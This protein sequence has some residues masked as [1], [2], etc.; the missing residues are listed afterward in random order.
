MG[1]VRDALSA[2]FPAAAPLIQSGKGGGKRKQAYDESIETSGGSGGGKRS[3]NYYDPV[4]S[5]GGEGT[6]TDGDSSDGGGMGGWVKRFGK[7]LAGK[8][9]D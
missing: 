2:A 5:G 1:I 7:R 8:R 4:E 6:P 3:T 9:S